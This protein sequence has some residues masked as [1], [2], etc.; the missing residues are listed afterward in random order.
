MTDYPD[1]RVVDATTAQLVPLPPYPDVQPSPVYDDT[2]LKAELAELRARADD[3]EDE[4]ARSRIAALEARPTGT[5]TTTVVGSNKT[6]FNSLG[7]DDTQRFATLAAKMKAGW[8]GEVEF[9][10]R[11]HNC[12]VQIPTAPG[13]WTGCSTRAFEYSKAPT[14]T[15]TG[16]SGTSMFVL[17]KNSGY[18]YPTNGVSRDFNARGIQFNAGNDKDFMPPAPGGF[19]GN[20]VQWYYSFPDC[21][22]VGW[23]NIFKGWGDGLDLPGFNNFQAMSAATP[24]ILGG[25]EQKWFL[26]GGFMDSNNPTWMAAD[27]PFIECS[28]SKSVIGSAMIS[29]R[30]KS[31]QLKVTY[32][33]GTRCIGTEFDSPDSDPTTGYQVR[34]VG[35]A[36]NFNF[37]LCSFKGGQ[38]IQAQSGATEIG[39]GSC[40]F[41]NNR[42]LA[43]LESGFTGVLKWGVDNT[44]GNCPRVIYAARKEQ[45]ICLD[46]TVEVRSL[47]GATVLQA[48]SR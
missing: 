26:T 30:R 45:V 35:S 12:P 2:A 34:F 39:V 32:G 23:R 3:D 9:E 20:Y 10:F 21:S 41:A 14:I 7:A 18:S 19:D 11:N 48:K 5:G 28:M 6:P 40:S 46:P 27:L 37:G 17:Y 44:Y 13:R 24:L 1:F 36:T 38:G 15:Y 31:Y 43:R 25:S 16:P 47:D 42:G 8:T 22:W 4:E 33:H 29:A